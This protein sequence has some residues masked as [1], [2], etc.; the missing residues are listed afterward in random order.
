MLIVVTG[1]Q[2]TKGLG[3]RWNPSVTEHKLDKYKGES[4]K[5][6]IEKVIAAAKTQC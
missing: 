4:T 6:E 1:D 2:E 3:R 5:K